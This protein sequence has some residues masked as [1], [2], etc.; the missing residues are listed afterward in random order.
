MT[1][2][3]AAASAK[4]LWYLTRASGAEALVLLTASICAGITSTLGVNARRWPRFAVRD[5]HRNL[6]LV[7]VVFTVR[8][9]RRRAGLK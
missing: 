3:A 6:T 2:L 9:G 5:L 7:A 1:V 8:L 4:E